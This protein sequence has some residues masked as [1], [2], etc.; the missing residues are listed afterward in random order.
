LGNP[1]VIPPYLA[2]V[3]PWIGEAACEN[4][5]AQ[6]DG[7]YPLAAPS[8]PGFLIDLWLGRL[9]VQ[10]TA[11][12]H[13]V[14]D[15][16]L[17]Y[18]AGNRQ[19]EWSYASLYVADDYIHADG[20]RDEAGDFAFFQDLNVMG[21]PLHGLPP[22]QSPALPAVR[23][24]YDPRPGGVRYEWREPD[25]VQ[26]RLRVI[27]AW[28][29]GPQLVVYNGHGN[30]YQWASTVRTLPE[31]FL[32]GTND[33]A[34]LHNLDRL[35]IVLAMTC[36]TG[37]FADVSTSGTTLDERF[38]RQDTGGAAAVWSSAGLTVIYGQE[39]L[40]R[41]FHSQLW[42]RPPGTAR[43]GELVEAGYFAL[44]N[45][46][47]CCQSTSKVYLLLGDPLTPALISAPVTNFLPFV[48]SRP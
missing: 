37:Q 23:I 44:F 6:L 7:D 5:F 11:Q 9:S 15:K 24:Y 20:T 8:D 48:Q 29:Q 36:L 35:A 39:A 40:M 47:G 3:D 33:V 31:P 1:N 41:G 32:F 22:Q 27:D 38:Q 14:V 13:T 30:Q 4:C 10:S 42:S 18:E 19:Q 43:L 45:Q 26:A 12:L 16:L 28:Q 46:Q 2:A 34:E 25:A 17:R 21:D